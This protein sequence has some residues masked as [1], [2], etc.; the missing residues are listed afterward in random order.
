MDSALTAELINVGSGQQGYYW[1]LLVIRNPDLSHSSTRM[2]SSRMNSS[3][4]ILEISSK[5]IARDTGKYDTS[6]WVNTAVVNILNDHIIMWLYLAMSLI[7]RL[8]R[9]DR[10]KILG[11]RV[12]G[13]TAIQ[14]LTHLINNGLVISQDIPQRN[15]LNRVL[16]N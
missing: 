9:T 8:I 5:G 2:I 1:K 6:V 12:A 14:L 11:Y 4:H 16:T 13:I 7:S 3:L 15:G 10:S